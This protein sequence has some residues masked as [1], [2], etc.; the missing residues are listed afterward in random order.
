M[1][2]AHPGI[3]HSAWAA[4]H[5]EATLRESG[6]MFKRFERIGQLI[7]EDWNHHRLARPVPKTCYRIPGESGY[8]EEENCLENDCLPVVAATA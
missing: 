5:L 6:L 2:S 4:R 3:A 1:I 8:C 7:L